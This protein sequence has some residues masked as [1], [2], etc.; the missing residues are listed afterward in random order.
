MSD[1]EKELSRAVGSHFCLNQHAIL[2]QQAWI[3]KFFASCELYTTLGARWACLMAKRSC[4]EPWG[5]IS[6]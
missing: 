2:L 4:L 3:L 5:A 1:G 6:V